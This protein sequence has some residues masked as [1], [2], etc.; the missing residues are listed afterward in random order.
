MDALGDVVNAISLV[1]IAVLDLHVDYLTFRWRVPENSDAI[2]K[3]MN[4]Q[5][6]FSPTVALRVSDLNQV[7]LE[8]QKHV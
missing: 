3:V 4:A 7:V 6:G 8:H 1:I 2:M 5:F